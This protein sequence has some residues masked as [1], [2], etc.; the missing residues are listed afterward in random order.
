MKNYKRNLNLKSLLSR[1]SVLLL[2]PRQTGKTTLVEREFGEATYYSLLKNDVFMEL[3]AHPHRLRE[4]LEK[5]PVGSLVAIDE[6]QRIPELLNEVHYLIE[7]RKLH[8]ILTGSSARKLRR[9][10]VNL[11]GGRATEVI[12]H[13]LNYEEI[14]GEGFDLLRIL[15][16]GTLPSILQSEAPEQ[17]LR[18]Y[19]GL[20]VREEIHAEGLVRKLPSFSRFLEVAALSNAQMINYT[21]I[22]SDAQIAPSVC[23]EYFQILKDTLIAHNL[24]CWQKSRKRKALSTGK[25]YFFDCGV[26]RALQNRS[27]FKHNDPLYGEALETYIFHELRTYTDYNRLAPLQ[28]WRS[29]SQLEVDFIFNDSIAI[30]VKSTKNPG[31]RDFSGLLALMEEKQLKGYLL[32]CNAPRSRIQSGITVYSIQDFLQDLWCKKIK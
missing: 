27:E 17:D 31:P 18:D 22:A 1:K 4:E 7:K 2:G 16:Y 29:T 13:P 19:V 14:S 26:A 12:F 30:E 25:Y 28:Y 24:P 8:F 23:F 11:L 21:R 3:N 15:N 32:V 10:G 5:K 20:Y 6:I 9:S